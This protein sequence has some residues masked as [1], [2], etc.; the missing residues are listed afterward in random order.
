MRGVPPPKPSYSLSKAFRG[1][2]V[3]RKRCQLCLL[4]G[5]TCTYW[6]PPT[7]PWA[8]GKTRSFVSNL[9]TIQRLSPFGRQRGVRSTRSTSSKKTRFQ[10][11]SSSIREAAQHPLGC[12]ELTKRLRTGVGCDGILNTST[13]P[14]FDRVI[15]DLSAS[16]RQVALQAAL[17]ASSFRAADLEAV[18]AEHEAGHPSMAALAQLLR[19]SLIVSQPPEG[20]HR[21]L[22]NLRRR[23]LAAASDAERRRAE[24]AHASWVAKQAARLTER[25]DT[26]DVVG[27]L[28]ALDRLRDD[29]VAVATRASGAPALGQ[30]AATCLIALDV[31]QWTRGPVG[32]RLDL[33]DALIESQRSEGS[34]DPVSLS[35]LHSS[36]GLAR[37]AVGKA[38]AGLA[39]MERAVEIASGTVDQSARAWALI[40]RAYAAVRVGSVALLAAS[41]EA[42]EANDGALDD[43]RINGAIEDCRAALAQRNGELESAVAHAERAISLH[44]SVGWTRLEGVAV[45]RLAH[46]AL[47]S[48]NGRKALRYARAARDL[49]AELG[50]RFVEGVQRVVVGL[51]IGAVGK[52]AQAVEELQ[53]A[54]T[55]CRGLGEQRVIEYAKSYRG[56]LRLVDGDIEGALS[57]LEPACTALQKVGAYSLALPPLAFCAFAHA[58]SGQPE[59][60]AERREEANAL[61]AQHDTPANRAV[62]ALVN[63]ALGDEPLQGFSAEPEGQPLEV[64]IAA[65]LHGSVFPV[66]GAASVNL[67]VHTL[68]YW[69]QHDGG[70]RIDCRRR[71]ALRNILV[72]LAT[73]RI[74][75]PGAGVLA[76][77]LVRVGWPGLKL[78]EPVARNRLHVTLHRLRELGLDNIL[79]A[80]DEGTYAIKPEV[81][82]SLSSAQ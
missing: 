23:V 16:E 69:F 29:L 80:T 47:D 31:L 10:T 17:F 81:H 4:G 66:P 62:L 6:S 68:G 51:A 52:S 71:G 40:S 3:A 54:E 18:M 72:R 21:L 26:E 44:R 22:N 55:F 30:S 37:T 48:G 79:E 28:D 78:S 27:A 32:D 67:T 75:Q 9:W 39:D 73:D 64:K 35:K 63:A 76:E 53:A 65:L 34:I 38:E 70:A 12:E 1:D 20:P 7:I 36:R 8:I 61:L 13:W 82:V 24:R 14:S 77:E 41:L 57:E 59:R 46:L 58:R 19:R 45:A 11:S 25:A 50:S 2:P 60:A 33:W 43:A 49:H 5:L 15:D 56:A 74:H 42:L